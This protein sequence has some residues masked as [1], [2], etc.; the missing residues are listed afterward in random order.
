MPVFQ[1]MAKNWPRLRCA[2]PTSASPA[3]TA[4]LMYIETSA[5]F[6][7]SWGVKVAPDFTI[8]TAVV[9]FDRP[10]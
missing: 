8:R 1:S 7:T 2:R 5:F 4:V 6:H 10:A 3:T 9:G